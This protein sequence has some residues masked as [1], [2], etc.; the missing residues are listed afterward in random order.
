[1]GGVKKRGNSSWMSC[2]KPSLSERSLFIDSN[3]SLLCSCDCSPVTP[4]ELS[5]IVPELGALVPQAAA[6]LRGLPCA[7]RLRRTTYFPLRSE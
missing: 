3:L 2:L 4:S 7:D 1:M 5:L 6:S